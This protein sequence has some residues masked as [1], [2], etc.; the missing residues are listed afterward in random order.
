MMALRGCVLVRAVPGFA[1]YRAKS[2]CQV[3]A[4]DALRGYLQ[5]LIG[6][7]PPSS[8]IE[9]RPMYP[10]GG[11]APG[12]AWVPVRELAEVERRIRE[13]APRLNVYVGAAPRTRREGRAGAVSRVWT[14]WADL[15]GEASLERLRGFEPPPSIVLDTGSE[16]HGLAVWPL[17]EPLAPAHAHRANRRL[18]IALGADPNASDPARILRPPA[19]LNHKHSP[20]RE[21]RCMRLDTVRFTAAEVVGRLP[22]SHHCRRPPGRLRPT[23]T[24]HD[25]RRPERVLEG[26]VRTVEQAR[27][28]TDGRPGDRNAALFWALCR[29]VEHVDAGE[30]DEREALDALSMTALEAGLGRDE[31]RAT[32]RS[33]QRTGRRAA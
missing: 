22:D 18:V 13:L 16:G 4:R 31:I 7:E 8:M 14:L 17:R 33:A 21:V 12:R 26:L 2:A 3:R 30:L 20:P 27:P 1:S 11:P 15:D 24:G 25:A 23:A 32:I 28:P 29:A 19:T 5:A 6:R 10:D 9:L